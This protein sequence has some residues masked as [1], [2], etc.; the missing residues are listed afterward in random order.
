MAKDENGQAIQ[1]T[2]EGSPPNNLRRIGWTKNTL[3]SGDHVIR[4]VHL[5]KIGTKEVHLWKVIRDGQELFTS[6]RG[7]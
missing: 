7:E 4:K 1:W 6:T 3:K 2:A 5:S